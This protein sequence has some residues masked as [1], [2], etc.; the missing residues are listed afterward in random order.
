MSKFQILEIFRTPTK[1]FEF[2]LLLLKDKPQLIKVGPKSSS[3]LSKGQVYKNDIIKITNETPEG[4]DF[5]L[6][7]GNAVESHSVNIIDYI[8]G[9]EKHLPFLNDTLPYHQTSLPLCDVE[10]LNAST[11][12]YNNTLFYNALGTLTTPLV[13]RI[14]Y[15]T[16]INTTNSAALKYY[17]FMILEINNELLK[18]VIWRE[19][20]KFSFLKVGDVIG[21]QK[22]RINKG[23]SGLLCL[24][25][26]RFSEAAYFDCKEVTGTDIVKFNTVLPK[27]N[28]KSILTDIKGFISYKSVINRRCHGFLDEY[29]LLVVDGKPV[30]LFYNS[31]SVFYDLEAGNQIE[32]SNLREVERA[33]FVFFIS[34]IFTQIQFNKITELDEVCS[35]FLYEGKKPAKRQHEEDGGNKK[36]KTAHNE[37]FSQSSEKDST[38]VSFLQNPKDKKIADVVDENIHEVFE[39]GGA[40]LANNFVEVAV[41]FIP[42][43]F[44]SVEDVFREEKEMLNNKEYTVPMFLRPIKSTVNE[45]KDRELIINEVSKWLIQAELCEV[46]FSNF[47][48]WEEP[49]LNTGVCISYIENGAI[50]EQL[51]A[52]I[53]IKDDTEMICYLMPNYFTGETNL[54]NLYNV[55]NKANSYEDVISNIGKTFN[56]IVQSFRA[57][58]QNVLYFI[59]GII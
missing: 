6:V 21:L 58:D 4:I 36:R 31:D 40:L 43:N 9:T 35:S 51:P 11:Y 24:D 34:T 53:K 16:R 50:K 22:Y 5:E 28:H 13:G 41:G 8:Y 42:D 55:V 45:L 25:Y 33:G 48:E 7:S 10:Q 18:V 56:F 3:K 30:V 59:T 2:V 1:D 49:K 17:F 29:Y 52:F 37:I 47:N 12:S 14:A 20:I 54:F 44:D 15:K 57:S 46:D 23:Y 38:E 19:N 39:N 27:N 26:N 32:I